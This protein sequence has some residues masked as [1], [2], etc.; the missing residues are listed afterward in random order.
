M[1]GAA[2]CSWGSGSFPTIANSSIYYLNYNGSYGASLTAPTWNKS[3]QGWYSVNGRAI[4][5]FR[6]DGSGNV[7]GLEIL[8]S[9]DYW[10]Y[11]GDAGEIAFDF[12]AF[13]YDTANYG[14]TGYKKID[15]S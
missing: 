14:I 11:V 7:Y 5:K 1:C 6:T 2:T 9:D 15:A 8:D 12:S 3:L 13:S 10:H 4:A